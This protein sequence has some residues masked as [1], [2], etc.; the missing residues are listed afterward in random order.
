MDLAITIMINHQPRLT[1]HG[2][3]LI[4]V[5]VLLA[6]LKDPLLKVVPAAKLHCDFLDELSFAYFLLK[7]LTILFLFLSMI[8]ISLP[9]LCFFHL[10][11]HP[12][13]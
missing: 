13:L 2:K 6:L 10:I 4:E 1:H 5:L 8:P 9:I 7:T 11:Q 12:L 3:R